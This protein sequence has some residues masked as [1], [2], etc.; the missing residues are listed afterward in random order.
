ME[1]L[2]KPEYIKPLI[3]GTAIGFFVGLLLYRICYLLS[4][5]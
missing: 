5:M 3:G 1:T 2:D 4:S